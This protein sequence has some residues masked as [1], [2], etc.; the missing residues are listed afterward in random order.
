VVRDWFLD[1]LQL[2]W[3]VSPIVHI[4]LLRGQRLVFAFTSVAMERL[5]YISIV[6]I[7]LSGQ[8]LVPGSVLFLGIVTLHF[9]WVS[10]L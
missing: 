6:H 4:Q 10:A 2:Q 9:C 8:I 5:S 1:L 3:N 7:Q